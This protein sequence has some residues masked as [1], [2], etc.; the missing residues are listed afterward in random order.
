MCKKGTQHDFTL[1]QLKFTG[2]RKKSFFSVFKAHCRT[3]NYHVLVILTNENKLLKLQL[4]KV[5]SQT[6]KNETGR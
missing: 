6:V 5:S 2:C 4:E 1:Y 3:A